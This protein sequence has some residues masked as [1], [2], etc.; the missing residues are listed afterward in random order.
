MFQKGLQMVAQRITARV[1][2]RFSEK[3]QNGEKMSL[4]AKEFFVLFV[5][6]WLG[7]SAEKVIYVICLRLV[8]HG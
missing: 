6:E 3:V 7:F 8:N 5:K 1:L 4:R 2:L